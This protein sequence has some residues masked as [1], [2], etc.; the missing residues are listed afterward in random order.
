MKTVCIVFKKEDNSLMVFKD[1]QLAE[2]Y[3]KEWGMQEFESD[4]WAK[5]EEDT[6]LN[7]FFKLMIKDVISNH[8][9]K[10]SI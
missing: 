3:L 1:K 2:E 6:K 7:N 4:I 9:E 10:K 8:E 5:T